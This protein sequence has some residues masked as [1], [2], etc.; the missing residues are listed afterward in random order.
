[1]DSIRIYDKCNNLIVEYNEFLDFPEFDKTNTDFLL[2]QDGVYKI[3]VELD[4]VT[5]T[6]DK[7]EIYVNEKNIEINEF[8][9]KKEDIDTET[10]SSIF[11]AQQK[12]HFFHYYDLVTVSICFCKNNIQ[13]LKYTPYI[14]IAT[15]KQI[16][17]NIE[18]MLNEIEEFQ[19]GLIEACFTDNYKLSGI[20]KSNDKNVATVV[21]MIEDIINCLKMNYPIFKNRPFYKMANGCKIV[22][23]EKIN[24]LNSKSIQWLFNNMETFKTIS[25][26]SGIKYRNRTYIPQKILSS[27]NIYDYNTYENI[28][29]VS[30]I[31]ELIIRVQKIIF[32]L[33]DNIRKAV[34]NIS[35][36][37]FDLPDIYEIPSYAHIKYLLNFY[38]N[39]IKKLTLDKNSLE[40][41]IVDYKNVL[42]CN[43]IKIFNKPKL[44]HVFRNIPHYRQVFEKIVYWYDYGNYNLNGDMYIFQLKKLSK[45]YEY[46]CLLNLLNYTEKLG[47]KL[48]E[49][50]Y[51]DYDKKEFD[52][53]RI[54]KNKY[55]FVNNHIDTE[56][57]I[58][59]E[60]TIYS[61][62]NKNTEFNLYKITKGDYYKPDFIIKY[63]NRQY[64]MTKYGILDAKFSDYKTIEK[65]YFKD[66]VLKYIHG[67][68]FIQEMNTKIL[69]LYL[70]YPGS[71]G[72]NCFT[73]QD[74]V[75]N[76]SQVKYPNLGIVSVSPKAEKCKKEN[77]IRFLHDLFIY[78]SNS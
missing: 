42:K 28:V 8:Y 3:E 73:W 31:E 48:I 58:Y 71:D 43:D 32:E 54:L 75:S 47:Y 26:G 15:K 68:D 35:Q 22:D 29:I 63:V 14:R 53:N 45:V 69:Y 55:V 59:Y 40:N 49:S 19:Q 78:T 36:L 65:Y 56:I 57:A 46:Y 20:K 67:I 10:I 62:K 6:Q 13:Y 60:P 76:L 50:S 44:T 41:L 64:N 17:K 2:F 37:K 18:E 72:F 39:A 61:D 77:F 25:T 4:D 1:M 30:F 74:D 11:I 21:N 23:Y 33:H 38:K 27:V 12:R 51:I 5:Y 24:T 34:L 16:T 7:V 9:I 66:E 70:L 52:K